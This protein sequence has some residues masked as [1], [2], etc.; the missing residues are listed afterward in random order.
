MTEKE[1]KLI[2]I[3][4]EYFFAVDEEDENGFK[5]LEL[6]TSDSTGFIKAIQS[7]VAESEAEK[8][9]KERLQ[10]AYDNINRLSQDKVLPEKDA[11]L[12]RGVIKSILEFL[13]D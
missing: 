3:V 10:N 4:K 2:E 12:I 9:D 11:T 13:G 1:A 6:D 5:R 7:A 8:T